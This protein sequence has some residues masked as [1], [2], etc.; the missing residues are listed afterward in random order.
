MSLDFG[1]IQLLTT[2]LAAFERLN[3]WS[4]HLISVDIDL[5]LFKLAGNKDMHNIMDEFE[6]R[7]DRS[8]QYGVSCPCASNKYPHRL[9][10]GK[11]VSPLFSSPEPKAHK[12]SL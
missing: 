7:P 10:M 5:I 12:V 11:M 8:T 4:H 2:V 9:I 1:Q 6:F 3:N